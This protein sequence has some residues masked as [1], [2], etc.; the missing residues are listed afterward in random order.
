AFATI[1][2]AGAL[3]IT[4]AVM[5]G[6][7]KRPR[8]YVFFDSTS[9][10][11]MEPGLTPRIDL[12]VKNFGQTPAYKTTHWIAVGLDT[13]PNPTE[14]PIGQHIDHSAIPIGPNGTFTIS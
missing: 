8:A 2:Q 11:G 7:T 4:I 13:F 3:I 1:L 9:I 14:T 10:Q 12:V 5:T 6:T